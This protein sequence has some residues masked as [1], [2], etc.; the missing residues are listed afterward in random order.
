MGF[1]YGN[2]TSHG[3]RLARSTEGKRVQTRFDNNMVAHVWAAQSQDFG[4]SNNGNYFFEGAALYSYGRHFLVGYILN[5]TALLNADSYSVST[6]QH[7]SDARSAV[8]HM[9]RVSVPDLTKWR[10]L[11]E[12]TGKPLTKLQRARVRRLL[13]E[14]ALKLATPVRE[15]AWSEAETG[16]I[17]VGLFMAD[18]FGLG[19]SWPA[20]LKAAEVKAAR[21]AKA[22]A[23]AAREADKREAIRFA[24]LPEPE[25]LEMISAKYIRNRSLTFYSVDSAYADMAKRLYRAVRTAKA[26]GFSDKRRKALSARNKAV[27]AFIAAGEPRRLANLIEGRRFIHPDLKRFREA[28]RDLA[29]LTRETYQPDARGD[30]AYLRDVDS[31]LHIIGFTGERLAGVP[32]VA[33]S[34]SNPW[35]LT[36]LLKACERA[37]EAMQPA[38][39]EARAGVAA[40]AEAERAEIARLRALETSEKIQAWREGK[41]VSV[42]FDSEHGGAALRVVNGELQTS[43]GASVPLAHAVRVFRFVKQCRERGES[44]RRNGKTIRVGHFTVDHIESDGSFRA[45]CHHIAWPEVERAAEAAGVADLAPSAEALEPSAHAA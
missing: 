25:W 7:Q 34:L 36:R 17:Q 5:G 28:V 23:K 33:K 41:P 10:D 20:I 21:E 12:W 29:A 18:L 26:E 45:G 14:Q 22:N 38:F 42:R 40:I 16:A 13:E 1:G 11:L 30:L 27:R 6:S 43:H 39:A 24:D 8:S 35:A 2:G 44:W 32:L 19:R 4:Q 9:V 37:R 15:Y 31:K 3:G